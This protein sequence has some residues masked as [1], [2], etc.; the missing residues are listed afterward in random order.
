MCYNSVTADK[1]NN[2]ASVGYTAADYG[3]EPEPKLFVAVYE[4]QSDNSRLLVKVNASECANG[5]TAAVNLGDDLE[6]G[7]TYIIK[8][9]MFNKNQQPLTNYYELVY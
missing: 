5:T 1:T 6:A 7:K 9:M 3:D 4:K 2:T 8:A